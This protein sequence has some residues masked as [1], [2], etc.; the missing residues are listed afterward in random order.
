MNNKPQSQQNRQKS[1]SF[2]TGKT[3]KVILALSLVA[4]VFAG[5]WVTHGVSRLAKGVTVESIRAV[6][7]GMTEEEVVAIL[8][9]PLER[10]PSEH[11]ADGIVLTYSKPAYFAK[12]YPMLW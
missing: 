10:G 2:D 8:G 9:D 7:N 6:E 3:G 12:W 11:Y 4:F 1:R 5:W